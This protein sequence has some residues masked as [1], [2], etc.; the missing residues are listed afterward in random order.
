MT[1]LLLSI[2]LFYFQR[3]CWQW[4][5][6]FFKKSPLENKLVGCIKEHKNI[7]A[8]WPGTL[9]EIYFT[10]IIQK[11]KKTVYIFFFSIICDGKEWKYQCP[12]GSKLWYFL[13][14]YILKLKLWR[15]CRKVGGGPYNKREKKNIHKSL[16]KWLYFKSICIWTRI[17]E[18]EK[19]KCV[20]LG[21]WL[22]FVFY[23]DFHYCL[24]NEY[25]N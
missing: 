21:L 15:L 13:R 19:W 8:F 18:T 10:E 3:L 22:I 24:C 4:K 12:H 16:F 14:D 1:S 25:L 2:A 7:E 6:F 20:M 5:L 17:E 9:T 11:T 23:S